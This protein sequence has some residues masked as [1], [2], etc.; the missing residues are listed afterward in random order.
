MSRTIAV[1]MY[2]G[3]ALYRTRATVINCTAFNV[4]KKWRWCAV[5]VMS[6]MDL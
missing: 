2:I 3:A 6:F 1:A 4:L 5:I